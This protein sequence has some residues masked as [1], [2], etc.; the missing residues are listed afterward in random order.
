MTCPGS[1]A[2]R[3]STRSPPP[4]SCRAFSTRWGTAK[5]ANRLARRLLREAAAAPPRVRAMALAQRVDLLGQPAGT[6]RLH[7][8]QIGQIGFGR[9]GEAVGADPDQAKPGGAVGPPLGQPGRG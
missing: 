4:T 8:E 3:S 5:S 6:A 9:V 2:P 7:I 1:A